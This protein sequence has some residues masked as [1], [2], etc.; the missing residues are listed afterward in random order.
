MSQ[1]PAS[2][3]IANTEVP[4]S[5]IPTNMEK[6]IPKDGLAFNERKRG[7]WLSDFALVGSVASS[8]LC[9]VTGGGAQQSIWLVL[10]LIWMCLFSIFVNDNVLGQFGKVHIS[11][12]GLLTFLIVAGFGNRFGAEMGIWLRACSP[13]LLTAS[14][15][16]AKWILTVVLSTL[17][18]INGKRYL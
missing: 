10:C 14:L 11:C 12:L 4:M 2:R 17:G 16:V 18:G 6:E 15:W 3:F 13:G 8:F 1:F 7:A 9:V 5:Y